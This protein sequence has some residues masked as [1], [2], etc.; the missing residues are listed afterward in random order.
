MAKRG[1]GQ[2]FAR[3]SVE[4]MHA[5]HEHG[6][7]KRSLGASNLVLLGIGCIIGTG[8]FVLTGRA[9]AEFAGPGDHD[10]LRHHRH[11]LRVRR[12]WLC[13]ARLGDPGFRIGLLLLL[14]LDG[15]GR[16]LDH[17]PAAGARIRSRRL[18]GGRGLVGLRRE[19]AAR[20]R[21]TTYPPALLRAPGSRSRISRRARQVGTGMVN[22]PALIGD[23]RRHRRCSSSAC[24]NRRTVNNI[25]V[26]IKVTVVIAF[27]VIGAFYV[28][29]RT[30]DAADSAAAA[31]A[32]CRR[33]RHEHLGRRS[34]SA[35]GD[36]VTGAER[37][38]VRRSAASSPPPRRSSSPISASRRSR[39]PARSRRTRPRTCRSAS[40]AR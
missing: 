19:P 17:G 18:D 1:F 20:S 26:A 3:K 10:L 37:R 23:R 8:I 38:P 25:V 21:H 5:E 12:A 4:Q 13:R 28:N 40:S 7:L 2:L 6:E 16:R 27:I 35:L 32:A 9:A 24:R 31:A 22:L 14:R 30:V 34:G 15:R 11:A 36:V 33:N 29:P 39:P